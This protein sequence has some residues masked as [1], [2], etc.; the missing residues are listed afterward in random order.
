MLQWYGVTESSLFSKTK[1]SAKTLCA[2][3]GHNHFVQL[4][5]DDNVSKRIGARNTNAMKQE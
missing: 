4:A 3:R 2:S 1:N 5:I